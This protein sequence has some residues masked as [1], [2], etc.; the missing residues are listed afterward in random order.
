MD[1]KKV[2]IVYRRSEAEMPA[3]QEEIERAKEEGIEFHL[4]TNPVKLIGDDKGSLKKMICIK[5]KLGEPDESGRRR[6]VAIAGSEFEISV[7]TVI[8]AIGNGPNPLLLDS[9]SGLSLNKRGYIAADEKSQTSVEDI[10]AGGDIVT[11]SATVIAAIGAGKIA[12]R[13]IDGY[14]HG[15]MSA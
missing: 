9:I 11:G 1:A 14:L 5:N 12:A 13:S 6:P 3:R 15:K 7:D 4:L 10:F 2:Y 8:C